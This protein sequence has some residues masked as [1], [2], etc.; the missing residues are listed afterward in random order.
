MHHGT[1]GRRI[2]ISAQIVLLTGEP[3][4]RTASAEVIALTLAPKDAFNIV[5]NRRK[6]QSG[7]DRSQTSEDSELVES[8]GGQASHG[9]RAWH[10]EGLHEPDSGGRVG[11]LLREKHLAAGCIR[12]RG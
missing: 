5:G 1:C 8:G 4:N 2:A 7:A 9:V 10:G 12:M 11:V 3:H 6:D